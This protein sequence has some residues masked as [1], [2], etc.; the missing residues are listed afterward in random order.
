MKFALK[1]HQRV[2]L[3]LVNFHLEIPIRTSVNSWLIMWPLA[4]GNFDA[5]IQLKFDIKSADGQNWM[6]F[7]PKVHRRVVMT[8]VNFRFDTPNGN[9][10]I[11]SLCKWSLKMWN[12]LSRILWVSDRLTWFTSNKNKSRWRAG[13]ER[14]KK[15]WKNNKFPAA[16]A[17]CVTHIGHLVC[18]TWK[19]LSWTNKLPAVPQQMSVNLF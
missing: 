4:L 6:K 18:W 5:L 2:V 1:V 10:N 16:A 3:L 11:Q 17:M 19:F 7:A 15:S 14:R 9:W 13:R 8:L 12:N